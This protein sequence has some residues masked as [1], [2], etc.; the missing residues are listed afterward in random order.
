MASSQPDDEGNEMTD[1]P[2]THQEISPEQDSDDDDEELDTRGCVPDSE[3]HVEAESEDEENEGDDYEDDGDDSNKLIIPQPTIS[4]SSGLANLSR[5]TTSDLEPEDVCLERFD[6]RLANAT[7]FMKIK[8]DEADWNETMSPET[9]VYRGFN[10]AMERSSAEKITEIFKE[11]I[12]KSTRAILGRS[13]LTHED[14]PKGLFNLFSQHIYPL[15]AP[16]SQSK[17]DF[18]RVVS[19]FLAPDVGKALA[20]KLRDKEEYEGSLC[21]RFEDAV[22][23]EGRDS[24]H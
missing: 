17:D 2:E 8:T 5:Q 4:E 24:E 9:W 13:N 14:S 21:Q 22:S 3:D 6:R 12:P 18:A 11:V 20:A 1:S 16:S 7:K 15:F 19:N 10:Q 23:D